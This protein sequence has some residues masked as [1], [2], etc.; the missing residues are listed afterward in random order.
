MDQ[1]ILISTINKRYKYIPIVNEL[2]I[3]QGLIKL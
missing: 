1:N 3:L 2:N